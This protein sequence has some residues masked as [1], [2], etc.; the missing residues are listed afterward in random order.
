MKNTLLSLVAIFGFHQ[1]TF[2]Q[3]NQ[4]DHLSVIF[5]FE[6]EDFDYAVKGM[7]G[8]NDSLYVISNTANGQGMLFSIDENG[9]G[10][11]V[12][13]EFDDTNYAPNS[14]IGNDTIIY[15][16]TRFSENGG[17]TLFQYSLQDYSFK[18]IKD[19]DPFDVQEV[20]IKY[21]TDS[22]LWLSSQYSFV[23]EGSIFTV[24][25]T[26]SNFK[27][28][29]N[30]TNF[31]KGQNP[32]D[33]VFYEN[34][35]YI[36]CYNGGGVPYPDG[37]G[38]TAASGSFIRINFDGT[39][40]E[41][42]I[43]GGD[44]KGTQP[45][46]LTIL[47]GKL[48]GLFA[49]SGSNG[50]MGAQFFR[51]NLD[52]S[53]YDSLGALD[54]RALTKLLATDSLIYGISAYN[55]FGINPFDGDIR[56]FE[57]LLSNPNFGYD[58]TANPAYLNG[59]VFIATQ[60]GGTNSGGT[61]LKWLNDDPQ[62]ID[63]NSTGRQ[64]ET[65]DPVNLNEL[66]TDP[67]GDL[68]TFSWVYD[69]ESVSVSES[70]NVLTFSQL[71]TGKTNIEITATDGWAGYKS[72]IISFGS[73]ETVTNLTETEFIPQFHPNPAN[74]IINFSNSN[75]ESIQILGLDGQTYLSF[76]NPYNQI[77]IDSLKSGLYFIWYSIEGN[78][79]SQKL[80]KL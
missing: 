61:I 34:K 67:E 79:Y 20:Q 36:A 3:N 9:D 2:A 52:G 39:G 41:N 29:Y 31:E 60:Q 46:S 22:V 26:G 64:L 25:K 44:D 49:Y 71:T 17:G 27:K 72:T 58:V 74:S 78:T 30:E 24:D 4:T 51:S 54:N 63:T 1:L 80:I 53:S 13:W 14:L 42:I 59:Q 12:I 62:I 8:T 65:N 6:G 75:I 5:D 35:I 77:N 68:L 21:M 11:N 38:S 48:F 15:G 66:F 57:D 50:F 7:V 47:E 32:V 70:N 56:I 43:K 76:K 28:L 16:T 40:Y 10:Y 73:E 45:Q 23:D 69:E 55:V 18:I 33:F 19:F 37:T